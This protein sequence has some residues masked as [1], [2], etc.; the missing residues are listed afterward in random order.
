MDRASKNLIMALLRGDHD[1]ETT[2]TALAD[3]KAFSLTTKMANGRTTYRWWGKI[4]TSRMKV[5]YCWSCH[6]NVAGF[7]LGWREV[8]DK[9]GKRTRDQ[10]LARKSKKR[11]SLLQKRRTDALIAK[12]AVRVKR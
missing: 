5:A 9:S 12:G 4:Q 8:Y 7:F 11:L 6:R 3:P 10:Y 1:Y 2:R